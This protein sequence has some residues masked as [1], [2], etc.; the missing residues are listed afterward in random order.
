MK[1][2]ITTIKVGPVRYQIR[3]HPISQDEDCTGR[4]HPARAIIEVDSRLPEDVYRQV[5]MHEICH[6]IS[7]DRS[8]RLSEKNTDGLANAVIQVMRDNPALVKFILK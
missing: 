1:K 2:K 4:C 5:L 6:A 8:L 3:P 7:F